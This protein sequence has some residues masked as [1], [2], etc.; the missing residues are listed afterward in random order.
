MCTH[1]LVARVG[2]LIWRRWVKFPPA[3]VVRVLSYVPV[4]GMFHDLRNG[5]YSGTAPAVPVADPGGMR[6]TRIR[7]NGTVYARGA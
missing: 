4:S 1:D 2:A 6:M 7:D 5:S 3:H